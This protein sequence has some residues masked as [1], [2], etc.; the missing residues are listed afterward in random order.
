MEIGQGC[1]FG[2]GGCEG[3]CPTANR[4][5]PGYTFSLSVSIKDRSLHKASWASHRFIILGV[6]LGM[7]VG[8]TRCSLIVDLALS[9]PTDWSHG[10][11]GPCTALSPGLRSGGLE[12]KFARGPRHPG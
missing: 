7:G 11:G 2:I 12:S 5:W 3:L 4:T 1:G 10:G 6:Y 9:G 8:K